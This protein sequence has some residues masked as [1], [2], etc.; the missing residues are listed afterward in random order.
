MFPC[1]WKSL[2]A[3]RP[4]A[5]ESAG[6]ARPFS[7]PVADVREVSSWQPVASG[8]AELRLGVDDGPEPE[9]GALRLDFDFHGSGGFAVARREVRLRMP[10]SFAFRFS[11]RG[12]GTPNDLEVKWVDAAGSSVWRHVMRLSGWPE[13]W[14]HVELRDRDFPFA[15][16]PAGGGRPVEAGAVE[17][18]LVAREGGCGSVWLSG[19]ILE[20]RTISERPVFSASSER[21][22]HPAAAAGDPLSGD[23]WEC[24]PDDAAPVWMVDW[25]GEREFGGM[26]IRWAGAPVPPFV[27]EGSGEGQTWHELARSAGT[28]GSGTFLALPTGAA[29][30]LRLCFAQT[31]ERCLP[32]I[33]SVELLAPEFGESRD[34]AF[35]TVAAMAPRG[36]YP[37]YWLREQSYWTPA[38]PPGGWPR[39]LMNEEGLVEPGVGGAFSIEP[40]LWADGRLLTWADAQLRQEQA[41][42]WMPVPATVWETGSWRLRIEAGATRR[43]CA[44]RYCLENISGRPGKVRLFVAV[45]PFQATPPWQAFRGHGGAGRLDVLCPAGPDGL[46]AGDGACIRCAPAPSGFGATTLEGGEILEV[47]ASGMLPAADAARDGGGLV[48]GAFAW[49]LELEPLEVGAVVV[50]IAPEGS[51]EGGGPSLEQAAQAWRDSAIAAP[52]WE[53]QGGNKE[54]EALIRAMRGAAAHIL[55]NRDGAALQPGPRRYQRCWIR[56]AAGMARALLY[57]GCLNEVKDLMIWYA[58]FIR[59]DGTV[60]CCV[61]REGPDWLPEHD[62]QGQFVHVLAEYAR[63]GGDRAVVSGLWPVA[64]RTLERLESLRAARMTEAYRSGNPPHRYG[65]LPESASHEGYLAHPVH[66]YWDDFWALRGLRDGAWLAEEL[67]ENGALTRIRALRDSFT[68]TLASSLTGLVAERGLDFVPGSVEWADFDPSATANGLAL[69]DE[70]P[71]VPRALLEATFARYLDG[72]RKRRDGEVPWDNYTPYEIRNA[73]AFVRMGWRAEAWELLRRFLADRRPPE[74]NQWPEIAWRNPL[75]P[76]HLGDVPHTWIGGEFV[77]AARSL[78]V[79]ERDSDASLVLAAGVPEAWLRELDGIFIRGWPTAWGSLTYSLQWKEEGEAVLRLEPGLSLPAG[80]AVISLPRAER[81][82]ELLVNG[83]A[84]PV[85]EDGALR[86][87]TCPAEVRVRFA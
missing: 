31:G 27:L 9:T 56:D 62:S 20:N 15:W 75:A 69:L 43:G 2:A 68:E 65:L 76:G 58:P 16:G 26:A 30:F 1:I 64:L 70:L 19:L 45:R 13:E 83:S 38:G 79:Y 41:E 28:A 57:A 12:R 6:S 73:G 81:V 37:R 77:A 66:A 87:R 25:R 74:W 7:G 50:T 59:E 55:V 33:L 54:T 48:S 34:A 18:A 63:F 11:F 46:L 85:G 60:P 47:L 40:F 22:G 23:S 72:F 52:A 86:L 36:W 71:G 4:A 21:E 24:A 80:G 42:G 84:Q 14:Q 3:S 17:F 61:D 51:R 35:H 44:V 32:A 49:D 82:A 39:G 67:G 78:F 29:R 53:F 5:A 10:E 8:E